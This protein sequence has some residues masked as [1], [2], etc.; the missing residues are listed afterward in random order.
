MDAESLA[1]LQR[2]LRAATDEALVALANR[3]LVRRAAKD[4]ESESLRIEETD[5]VVLVHGTGW[6]VTMPPEGPAAATDN[7]PATGVT[8]Q[9]L[10]AAM[11]LRDRWLTDAATPGPAAANS[12]ADSGSVDPVAE[13]IRAARERLMDAPATELFKWAG[14]TPVLEASASLDSIGPASISDAPHLKVDFASAGVSVVLMTD[15]PAKTLRKLL[16]QFKTTSNK[17]EQAR[18]VML[19]VLAIKRAAGKSTAIDSDDGATLSEAVRGDRQ[20]I[21]SR[22]ARLLSAIAA[23]GIAHPSS[24]IVERLHTAS[25]AAEAAR[26]P[27]LA[28]L[29]HSLASDAELQIACDAGADP[30]RMVQRM[31]VAHALAE[32]TAR[33]E[34][35]QR[36]DL[37]GR[38]RTVYSPAGDLDLC[39][40]GAH[41]WR[42]ASGYE[43]LATV[44]WDLHSQQFFTATVARGDGQDRTFTLSGA[45]AS[46]LGW[47]G[48]AAV[49]AMCR[50]R[51]KL[52][53]AKVNA[54]GRLSTA[55]SC[56]ATVAEPTNPNE[57]DFGGRAITHW[58]DLSR[59]LRDSQPLGLR[60]PDP[61]ATLV[62]IRPA[63][64]GKRWFDE[65][66]Q[67]FVWQLLDSSGNAV[68]LRVPW[69]EITEA[70]VLFL[71]SILIDRDQPTAILG[72]IEVRGPMMHIYPLSL[73]SSGSAQGDLI[74]CPQFDQFRIRS[75]N[76]ALLKRLREKY[77]R[78]QTVQTRIG[79]ESDGEIE[80]NIDPPSSLPPMLR[81][82]IFDVESVLY[83]AL[84][85]GATRL[86]EVATTT[87]VGARDRF[88][89]LGLEPMAQSLSRLVNEAGPANL[90]RAAYRLH[91]LR[92]SASICACESS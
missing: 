88:S 32:A 64:W 43:G 63:Q 50:K 57:I 73:F 24:R 82:L 16:D 72:R 7:T 69:M 81:H 31:V 10:T 18:W 47:S 30:N 60:V 13:S 39:G 62:V 67:A 92:Q 53:G 25:V 85:T 46:G 54:E 48:G 15:Q 12:A 78:F 36:S 42:T 37:F 66:D 11:Y 49:E 83:A 76:E 89:M 20:R 4:L 21:A 1:R 44:F 33:E 52:A 74:L 70:S 71:E 29:L 23:S 27:R 35:A 3:G 87:V 91:L 90:L 9:I 41:G 55:E 80:G 26:H 34:N 75:P 8:R 38:P 59:V 56:R 68:E 65:L 77:H 28:R 5:D 79:A 40:L 86:S 45:Y 17:V 22:S 84:E 19:A 51:V 61:R 6:T 58:R 14:K 2:N